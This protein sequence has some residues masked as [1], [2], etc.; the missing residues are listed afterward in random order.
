M[1]LAIWALVIGT[2]LIT[3]AVSGTALARLPISTAM[4]YLAAGYGL[5]PAG[6]GLMRPDPWAYSANLEILAEIAVLISL[7]SVGL[8]LGRPLADKGWRLPVR[9]ATLSMTITVALIAAIGIWGF[10]LSLGAAVL[11]GAIIAPTDPVLASEIQV[12]E[13]GDRDRL[14]AWRNQGIT[15]LFLPMPGTLRRMVCP[16]EVALRRGSG[17]CRMVEMDSPELKFIGDAREVIDIQRVYRLGEEV[18]SGPG[19]YR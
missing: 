18:W 13:T 3:M 10:G 11:L 14:R 19:A 9:L 5:G 1:A 16:L 12:T 4:L 15:E 6:L 7:F 2:L 8:K 17:N